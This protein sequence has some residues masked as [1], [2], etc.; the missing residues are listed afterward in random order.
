MKKNISG[1]TVAFNFEATS[2]A[3]DDAPQAERGPQHCIL[4]VFDGSVN[5][6]AMTTL[7]LLCWNYLARLIYHP[8][9]GG[10]P[11]GFHGL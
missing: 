6:G 5:Q 10:P 1:G 3:V 7:D 2:S 11:Y 8:K 9:I 4:F